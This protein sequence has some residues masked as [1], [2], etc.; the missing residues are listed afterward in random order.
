[1][2][3]ILKKKWFPILLLMILISI[4]AIVYSYMN[5]SQES[6]L[7]L[8]QSWSSNLFHIGQGQGFMTT[9]Q[10]LNDEQFI[11]PAYELPKRDPSLLAMLPM[12]S[13]DKTPLTFTSKQNPLVDLN[14]TQ[15]LYLKLATFCQAHS[16]LKHPLLLKDTTYTLYVPQTTPL[17]VRLDLKHISKTMLT[18]LSKE[19]PEFDFHTTNYDRVEAYQD[20]NK[21]IQYRYTWFVLDLVTRS[22]V[23]FSMDVV[24]LVAP[25]TYDPKDIRQRQRLS[26]TA[27][28]PQPKEEYTIGIPSKDQLIPTPMDVIP[29]GNQV[30][31]FDS[32]SPN[33]YPKAA[34][35]I[36]NSI[37]IRHSTL[38]LG[39]ETVPLKKQI[40]G[41]SNNMLEYRPLHREEKETHTPEYEKGPLRNKWITPPEVKCDP[42]GQYPC[43]FTQ[44]S[45]WN[46]L[47]IYEPHDR[48][49]PTCPGYISSTEKEPKQ[50]YDNPTFGK[51]P[52]NGGAYGWMFNLEYNIP[53]FPFAHST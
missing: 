11:R 30:I 53:S 39:A 52:W 47:G 7:S 40:D 34:E 3:N 17:P 16:D 48:Q 1:M 49:K 41:V 15:I 5:G 35:Y 37:Q 45:Q 42:H 13:Q 27:Y 50:P 6:F 8:L 9:P 19:L 33:E 20:S 22:S 36:L 31:R 2:S 10:L 23:G 51:Y 29:T 25:G 18:W 26:C 46:E 14:R 21:N 32:I 24:K 38:T 12:A 4:I 28:T 43:T 44:F